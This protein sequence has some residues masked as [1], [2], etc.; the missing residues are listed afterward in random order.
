MVEPLGIGHGEQ[1]SESHLTAF[2]HHVADPWQQFDQRGI[3]SLQRRL[4]VHFK[5]ECRHSWLEMFGMV[6]AIVVLPVL[7]G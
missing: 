6:V 1:D 5:V 2:G 3:T 7:L 4:A